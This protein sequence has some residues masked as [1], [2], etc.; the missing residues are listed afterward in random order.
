MRVAMNSDR[1]DYDELCCY[2]LTR[3]DPSFVHQHVVDA[4]TAQRADERTKPIAL[5]FA[6]AG[7]Y[8]HSEKQVSGKQVQRVHMQM[9]Q[10]KRAWPLFALPPD[11]GAITAADVLAAPSGPERDRA[12][13]AWCN[14]VWQAFR[15]SRPTVVDLLQE[16]GVLEGGGQ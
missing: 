16:C 7:L 11:R 6:L 15:E 12:I 4:F 14:S 2:T 1:D 10:K 3:G 5:T 8:L 13:D 9:A